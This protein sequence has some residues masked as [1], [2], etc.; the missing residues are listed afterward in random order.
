[1]D[2]LLLG[3]YMFCM[4]SHTKAVTFFVVNCTYKVVICEITGPE[5]NNNFSSEEES[6]WLFF[7]G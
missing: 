1:M 7:A 3:F 2:Y 5:S 6:E 4:L